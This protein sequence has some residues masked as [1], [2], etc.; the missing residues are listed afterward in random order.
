MAAP[1]GFAFPG[2][3]VGVFP[4][5][6]LMAGEQVLYET[7]PNFLAFMLAAILGLVTFGVGG[8]II[9]LVFLPLGFPGALA[10]VCWVPYI[11]VLILM[12]VAAA[13]QYIRYQNTA[14]AI[15]TKRVMM[16][17][18]LI[19]RTQVECTHEKVQNV[20]MRQGIVERLLGVGTLVFA[21]AG[22]GGGVMGAAG[23]GGGMVQPFGGDVVFYAIGN[24]VGTKAIV[25]QVIEQSRRARRTE[26][27]QE[28]AA[29]LGRGAPT[30]PRQFCSYCGSR[31][32]PGAAV[33]GACGR[34]A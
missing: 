28:M 6:S 7:R 32:Q 30:A 26:E 29:V 3:Q 16:F 8:A 13:T 9:L 10:L 19:G 24:P 5:Q 12:G 21:T 17:T 18:A 4:R 34:P 14:Y 15:T 20:T 11:I 23:W 1:Q 22:I 33:C 2:V 25:D 27:L 31:L